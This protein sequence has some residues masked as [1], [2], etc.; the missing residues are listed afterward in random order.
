MKITE[1][2]KNKKSI[3]LDIELYKDN[4]KCFICIGTENSSGVE[5][6]IED[7]DEIAGLIKDYIEEL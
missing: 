4:D 2:L 1:L 6:P 5:Y 7:T 3:L